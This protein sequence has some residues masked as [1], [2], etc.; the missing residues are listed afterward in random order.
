MVADKKIEGISAIRDESDREGLRVVVELRRGADP[1]V[2][3]N[4]LYIRTALQSTFSADMLAIVDGGTKPERLSLRRALELFI[5]FRCVDPLL[6]LS[7]LSLTWLT[8]FRLQ[9]PDCAEAHAARAGPAA[10]EAACATGRVH[11]ADSC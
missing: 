10:G 4:N 9:D 5:D 6:I 1:E 11:C 7:P 3:R 2:V 8:T